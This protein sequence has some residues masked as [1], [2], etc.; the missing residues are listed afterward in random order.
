MDE[1][2]EIEDCPPQIRVTGWCIEKDNGDC[3]Q[4]IDILEE[5]AKRATNCADIRSAVAIL[6]LAANAGAL[7]LLVCKDRYRRGKER[8]RSELF[9]FPLVNVRELFG[10]IRLPVDPSTLALDETG[11]YYVFP[12]HFQAIMPAAMAAPSSSSSSSSKAKKKTKGGDGETQTAEGGEDNDEEGEEEDE[13]D[14][15]EATFGDAEELQTP[16]IMICK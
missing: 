6:Q 9:G 13:E 10:G 16:L 1:R 15:D 4:P 11:Q 3:M 14:E 8:T 7:S 12:A 2:P 5:H